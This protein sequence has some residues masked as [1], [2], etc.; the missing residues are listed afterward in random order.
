[1]F[2]SLFIS[3]I[4]RP[5]TLEIKSSFDRK[6]DARK[7]IMLGGL[8]VKAG[9]DYLHPENAH[10]LYGM[11]LGKAEGKYEVAKNMLISDSDLFL[12]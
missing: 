4:E 5:V 2:F 9:L 12:K 1:M 8:F 3:S 6:S 7:K 11:L 10:I